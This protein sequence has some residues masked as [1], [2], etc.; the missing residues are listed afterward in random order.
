VS[1]LVPNLG[2]ADL[3]LL[4]PKYFNAVRQRELDLHGNFISSMTLLFF[5]SLRH[6]SFYSMLFIFLCVSKIVFHGGN[7]FVG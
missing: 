6:L 1:F 2:V 3:I 7:A 5:S 4:S